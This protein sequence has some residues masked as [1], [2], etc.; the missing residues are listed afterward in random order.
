MLGF[1][2]ANLSIF[3]PGEGVRTDSAPGQGLGFRVQGLGSRVEGLRFRV[4]G[5]GCR[6]H[7]SGIGCR[8]R[9]YG[10]GFG[11]CSG[12]G[13]FQVE[14]FGFRFREYLGFGV[15]GLHLLSLEKTA[16]EEF[17]GPKI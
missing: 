7:V 2:P 11:V 4:S 5:F 6:A 15:W 10:L 1:A 3:S 13:L 8:V 16:V 17:E 12:C 9:L 14:G